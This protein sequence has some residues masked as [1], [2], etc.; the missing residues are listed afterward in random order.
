LLRRYGGAAPA[1][2][3][4]AGVLDAEHLYAR[5][6]WRLIRWGTRLRQRAEKA[7]RTGLTSPKKK[8]HPVAAR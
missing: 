7:G 5:L 8:P 2:P 6:G 3:H 4:G 1:Q